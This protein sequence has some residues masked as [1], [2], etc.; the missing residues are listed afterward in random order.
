[1]AL[2]KERN[3][4]LNNAEK[5]F[6]GEIHGPEA[7]DVYDGILYTSLHGGSVSK[8]VGNKFV[9]VVKFGKKCEGLWEEEKCGRPL[10]LKFDKTGNLYVVDT[11]YG[12]FKVNINTKKYEKIVDI[13]KPIA[14]K[15]PMLPNSIDVASNG[16]LY[17]TVSD[18]QFKLNDLVFSFLANPSG[19]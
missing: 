10:G 5:L 15:L 19:R 4:K 17:W 16:D 6:D 13:T 1:M 3:G 8:L 7:F 18:S 14:G 11:Y 9:E 12:I 2:T